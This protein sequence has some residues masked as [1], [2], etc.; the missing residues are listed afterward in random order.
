MS[1]PVRFGMAGDFIVFR[2]T[3]RGRSEIATNERGL[4]R[5]LR[6]LLIL[7]DGQVTVGRLLQLAGPLGARREHFDE[8]VA[9]G[10]IEA[11]GEAAGEADAEAIGGEGR[12]FRAQDG[13]Q[14][15]GEEVLAGADGE[16][17]ER[18]PYERFAAGQKYLNETIAGK[19]GLKGT[20]FVLKIARCGTAEDLIALLPEFEQIMTRRFDAD[21][22]QHCRAIAENLLAP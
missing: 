8:L 6:P 2:K 18:D 21:Y 20:F 22:A 17:E 7:I 12:E 3:A 5:R 16:Y 1:V 9:H 10:M 19:V 15:G 13:A 4:D 14:D 11:V